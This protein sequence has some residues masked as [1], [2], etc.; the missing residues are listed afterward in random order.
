MKGGVSVFAVAALLTTAG[1]S[2]AQPR[3]PLPR[4]TADLRGASVGLPTSE[5]WTP[6]VPGGTQ[7]PARALGFEAGAHVYPAR[8]RIGALGLGATALLSRGKTSPEPPPPG[9]ESPAVV[10]PDVT[11]RLT[12]LVPQVSVNFGHRLGWSYLS[13]GMGRARVESDASDQ[14]TAMGSVDAPWTRT[15]NI[16]GGAR[17]FIND[18]IGVGLDLR[19]HMLAAVPQTRAPKATLLVA[20]AGIAIK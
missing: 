3:A 12:S 1:S 18:H 13:A 17:W 9:T 8:F 2:L 16:G 10:L 7:V 4:F 20:G 11:T 6:V 19:W 5:G 14:S 15:I